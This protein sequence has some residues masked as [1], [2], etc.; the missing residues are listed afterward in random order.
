LPV[1]GDAGNL[2][3]IAGSQPRIA[4]DVAGLTAEGVHAADHHVVNGS[5][6]D[7][8]AFEQPMKCGHPQVDR[9]HAGK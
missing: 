4:T 9:M 3:R 1:H 5:G 7:V 8:D 2:L 6:V